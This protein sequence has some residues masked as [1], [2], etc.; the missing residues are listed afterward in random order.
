MTAT[1]PQDRCTET[2]TEIHGQ[3]PE[4]QEVRSGMISWA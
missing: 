2:C 4:I 3:I 1:T